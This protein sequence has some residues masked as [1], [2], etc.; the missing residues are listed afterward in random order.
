M[1]VVISGTTAAAAAVVVDMAENTDEIK[2]V[3][4][5]EGRIVLT[6]CG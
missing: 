1:S 3:I 2:S 5:S 4:E 6:S